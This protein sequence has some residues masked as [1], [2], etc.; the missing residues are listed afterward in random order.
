MINWYALQNAYLM[1]SALILLRKLKNLDTG[2]SLN[3][4][5]INKSN[6]NKTMQVNKPVYKLSYWSI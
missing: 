5:I 6:K 2:V 1:G 4:K 3:I